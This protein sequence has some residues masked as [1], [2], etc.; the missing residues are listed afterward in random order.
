[1]S[2]SEYFGHFSEKGDSQLNCTKSQLANIIEF[3]K[4]VDSEHKNNPIIIEKPIRSPP[5]FDDYEKKWFALDI[6][7]TFTYISI[8]EQLGIE[9]LHNLCCAKVACEIIGNKTESIRLKFQIEDDFTAEEKEQINEYFN[10][11]DIFNK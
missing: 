5:V 6:D 3:L 1:M 8:A 10:W 2:A 4:H 7:L 9:S 11:V